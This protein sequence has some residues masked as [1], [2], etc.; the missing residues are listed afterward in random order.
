[1]S[2]ARNF[3][4]NGN[5]REPETVVVELGGHEFYARQKTAG[6]VRKFRAQFRDDDGEQIPSLVEE[7]V[8]RKVI[9]GISDASGAP[10]FGEDDLPALMNQSFGKELEILAAAVDDANFI[11]QTEYEAYKKKSPTAPKNGSSM[12]SASNS[13]GPTSTDSSKKSGPGGSPNG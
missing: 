3:I 1:M 2:E 8:P 11:S 13:G 9:W 12:N 5:G 7:M 10:V 4:L 6:S